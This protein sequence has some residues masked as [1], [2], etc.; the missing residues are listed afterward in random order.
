MGLLRVATIT[1][2][3]LTGKMT[4]V[5]EFEKKLFMPITPWLER[6]RH[7]PEALPL[8][9]RR[10]LYFYQKSKYI[11]LEDGCCISLLHRGSASGACR[12]LLSRY[13]DQHLSS[14]YSDQH[15]SSGY[16]DQHLADTLLRLHTYGEEE[17]IFLSVFKIYFFKRWTLDFSPP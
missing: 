13:S 9:G 7:A 11:S 2:E 12:H 15:L 17:L 16:L 14:G 4:M 5:E 8:W 3:T 1:K 6:C 10:I